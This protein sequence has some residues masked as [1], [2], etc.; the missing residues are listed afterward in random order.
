MA[1]QTKTEIIG[2]EKW[3]CTQM[4]ATQAL[5]IEGRLIGPIM[6]A[7]GPLFGSL[8]QPA[9][10]QAAAINQA[11]AAIARSV[12]PSEFSALI[13]ELCEQAACD[14]KRVDFDTKFTGGTGVLLRYQ[15]AWFVLRVNYQ[16]FFDALL[17]EGAGERAQEAILKRMTGA[18]AV[19][20]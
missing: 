9:E 3:S 19:A 2:G 20:A 13:R 4:P 14:G 11:F 6:Q 1:A 12:P 16:D 10:M 5:A 17:P 7:I 15:V 8:G 18:G